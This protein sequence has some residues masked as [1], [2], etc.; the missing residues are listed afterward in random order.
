MRTAFNKG[1]HR[2][3]D[4]GRPTQAVRLAE[5]GGA[6][7]WPMC[8]SCYKEVVDTSWMKPLTLEEAKVLIVKSRL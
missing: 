1:L 7:L 5:L 6:V 2:C 3:V 8:E 4:C